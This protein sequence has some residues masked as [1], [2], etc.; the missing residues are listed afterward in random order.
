MMAELPRIY[1]AGAV[2]LRGAGKHTE[3]LTVFRPHRNDWSLPKGKV[4]PGERLAATAVREVFEETGIWVTLGVPL[5]TVRYKVLDPRSDSPLLSKKSVNYW[6]AHVDDDAIEIG[7]IDR[8]AEWM[9][10]DEVSELRWVRASKVHAHLTYRHDVDIVQEALLGPLD[11]SAFMVL[12]HADAEK[13]VDFRAREG[14]E[15]SDD[16]RPLT[17]LGRQQAEALAD[18]LAAFGISNVV[19][20]SAERTMAT[21]TPFATEQQLRVRPLDSLTE[22]NFAANPK[23]GLGDFL[24]LLKHAEGTVACVH[25]PTMKRLLRGLG[26]AFGQTSP[27]PSL[28]PAEYVVLHRPVRRKKDGS[29]SKVHLGP[30]VFPEYG[31]L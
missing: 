6:R 1:A 23:A 11:T 12:R 27:D 31:R 9:P 29:I 17:V 2:V 25:R 15:A 14:D 16:R 30:T 26:S 19:S 28:K 4:D 8:P 20:S 18:V 21:V 22:G 10:N 3:V 13:R 5:S 24:P 7:D